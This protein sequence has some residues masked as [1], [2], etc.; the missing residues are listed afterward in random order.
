MSEKS[1][2]KKFISN[3]NWMIFQ[4]IY[5]MVLSL[6]I[7]ALVARYL[8]PANYGILNYATSL[9]SFFIIISKL[10]IDSIIVNELITK[11]QKQ[12]TVLGTALVMRLISSVLSFILVIV[13]IRII[14]PDDKLIQVV[15]LL[16]SL[17]L[18][19]QIYEVFTFWFQSRLRMKKVAISIICAF[20]VVGFWRVFLLVKGLSVQWFALSSSI[21]YIV[22]GIVVIIFYACDTESPKL[23][24]DFSTS[25]RLF[26][27]GY[28][29][30][31]SGLAITL[32][33]QIDKIII[34]KMIDSKAVG[35]YSIAVAISILWEFVPHALINSSRPL[36]VEKR[37]KSYSAY[38]KSFQLL[39][40][41]ITLLG[42]T[43]DFAIIT[44]GKPL[45]KLIYGN[46]YVGAY[47]PLCF[48]IF[49]TNFAVIGT[50]RS[51][52]IVAE[53][54]NKFPK[55][56]VIIGSIVNLALNFIFI[57]WMGITGA[58]IA[59]LVSQIVVALISPAF[60]KQ[61]RPFILIYIKSFKYI[62]DLY[63][64]VIANIGKILMRKE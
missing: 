47:L 14:E 30:I 39:L 49:S 35:I 46:A 38:I 21:Q 45:I 41:A 4:Q 43:V 50:A 27:S 36:I 51:I 55:Y 18:I 12:G 64:L 28:H 10:G 33:T 5:N 2:T 62:K 56:Y 40:L 42:V 63:K 57:H 8:G 25:K 54:Y 17:A 52:W 26:R 13:A 7:G 31:I 60:F 61:T 11:P 53:G 9:I 15:T 29:F 48:L 24:F 34:K 16:Q 20:T 23:R 19:F 22:A 44:F 37:N 6:V 3:I 1:N 32:Y 58:A 59:T